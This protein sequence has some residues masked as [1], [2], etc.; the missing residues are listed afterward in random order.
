[1]KRLKMKKTS[2]N[3]YDIHLRESLRII[4]DW[5]LWEANPLKEEAEFSLLQI[6]PETKSF[7]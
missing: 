7:S 1:M 2:P 6:N 4:R 5:V 3:F